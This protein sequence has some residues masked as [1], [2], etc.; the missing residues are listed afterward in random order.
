MDERCEAPLTMTD[1]TAALKAPATRLRLIEGGRTA[2]QSSS[3]RG[4][5]A[6]SAVWRDSDA[7]PVVSAPCAS[8]PE[9]SRVRGAVVAICL[10]AAL[11]FGAW[12]ASLFAHEQAYATQVASVAEQT[13]IV[14]DGDS[15]LGL[16]AEHLVDGLDAQATA[17]WIAERNGLEVAALLPGQH[18]VVPR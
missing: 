9:P 2:W 6:A 12:G 4:K 10:C 13:V 16:A 7:R 11:V 3:P 8:T 1:G 5:T 18:L 15:L 14:V 17:H